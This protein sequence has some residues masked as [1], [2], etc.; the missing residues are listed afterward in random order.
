MRAPTYSQAEDSDAPWSLIDGPRP[1]SSA[2]PDELS[3]PDR[4]PLQDD[5]VTSKVKAK[6]RS[7]VAS[8]ARPLHF[9][10]PTGR[11]PVKHLD[12]H[13]GASPTSE[14]GVVDKDYK[15]DCRFFRSFKTQP[16]LGSGSAAS[17][18]QT[19]KSSK[20]DA[21]LQP[22]RIRLPVEMA[23]YMWCSLQILRIRPC[24]SPES[25]HR[26]PVLRLRQVRQDELQVHHGL[27]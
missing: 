10:S 8:S 18:E 19:N 3:L 25:Q 16:Q 17:P 12:A 4:K 23:I 5:N 20:A 24:A 27:Q 6:S 7:H 15:E 14:D 11:Q 1:S 13:H 26:S 22:P 21:K 2:M 9:E